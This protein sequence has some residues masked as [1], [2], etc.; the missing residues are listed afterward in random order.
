MR[1]VQDWLLIVLWSMAALLTGLALVVLTFICP[2]FVALYEELG[3]QDFPLPTLILMRVSHFLTSKWWILA[4]LVLV[5]WLALMLLRRTPA[6]RAW[7]ERTV[8][9][10]R[11]LKV[12]AAVAG[13][14]LGL[15]AMPLTV[16]AILLPMVTITTQLA[17]P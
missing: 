13:M 15:A 12:W 6:G 16:A 8:Q 1:R 4:V 7:W 9:E 5:G 3:I 10:N 11:R 17:G 14:A 2:K